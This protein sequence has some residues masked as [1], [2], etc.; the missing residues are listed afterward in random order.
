M[1]CIDICRLD[2]FLRLQSFALNNVR[3]LELVPLVLLIRP[4][5]FRTTTGI[6][7]ENDPLSG[8]GSGAGRSSQSPTPAP[9][10]CVEGSTAWQEKRFWQVGIG[11][12]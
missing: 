10:S 4:Y 5:R 11:Q 2:T 6:A 8:D 9:S 12:T 7:R 3:L 1:I